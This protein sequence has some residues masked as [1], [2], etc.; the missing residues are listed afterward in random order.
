[1]NSALPCVLAALQSWGRKKI[2]L[3]LRC[4]E[5]LV[6]EH[7]PACLAMAL[8][9]HDGDPA[10]TTTPSRSLPL[11][12]TWARRRFRVPNHSRAH[13]SVLFAGRFIPSPAGT[14]AWCGVA[15]LR[16]CAPTQAKVENTNSR[17]NLLIIYGLSK[18]YMSLK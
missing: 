6:Q 1:M 4:I 3:S 7:M 13:P 16:C 14:P 15:A 17:C 18:D 8:S 2:E 9:S 12:Q 5:I 11:L 10:S